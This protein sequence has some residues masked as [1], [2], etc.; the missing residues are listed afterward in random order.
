MQV[1]VRRLRFELQSHPDEDFVHYICSGLEQGFDT[2]VS[3]TNLK[4]K[5]C[6]NLLT[7]RDNPDI[8]DELL[9]TECA[10]Q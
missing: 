5:E 2:L 3:D 6:N 1:N 10:N 9:G 8:V 4:T 7:A